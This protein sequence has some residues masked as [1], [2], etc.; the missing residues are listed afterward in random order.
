M[1]RRRPRRPARAVAAR[2]TR[3]PL[4]AKRPGHLWFIDFTR[5]GGFLRSVVVGAVI[6]GFSRR[7]L[8]IAVA[9]R[10]PTAAFAVRLLRAAVRENGRAPTCVIT[11]RGRQFTSKAFGRALKRRGIRRRF[12]RVGSSLSISRIDR[13]WRSMKC[14]YARS[15]VLYRPLKT[16][17]RLLRGY[18]TW[19]NAHRP[20]QGLGGRTP[21][22]AHFGKSTR[23]KHVALRAAVEVTHMDSDRQLPVLRLRR[24]G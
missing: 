17:D 14:E 9:P 22:E 10:E 4:V 16:I 21:D 13:F 19:F 7:V 23:A 2:G 3:G 8:S 20:H 18:A 24:A 15:L 11:D 12:G 1:L 6:D 5:V